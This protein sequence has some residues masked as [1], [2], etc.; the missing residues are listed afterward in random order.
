VINEPAGEDCDGDLSG[1]AEDA[2]DHALSW[3]EMMRS[4]RRQC[5]ICSR[6][7]CFT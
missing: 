6:Q 2:H 4:L 3:Y 5:S 7:D 1:F